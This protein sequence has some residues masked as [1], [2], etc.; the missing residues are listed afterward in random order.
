MD[1]RPEHIWQSARESGVRSK[2]ARRVDRSLPAPQAGYEVPYA[3]SIGELRNLVDDGIVRA[4]G[5]S[6]VGP[7]EVRGCRH[8]GEPPRVRSEPLLAGSQRV[9]R[10]PRALYEVGA[11]FLARS[12]LGGKES[13]EIKGN[14]AFTAMGDAHGVGPHGSASLG[15]SG[16]PRRSSR[17]RESRGAGWTSPTMRRRGF[18]Q[19]CRESRDWYGLLPHRRPSGPHRGPLAGTAVHINGRPNIDRRKLLT[20]LKGATSVLDIPNERLP[21]EAGEGRL[22]SVARRLAG[23]GSTSAIRWCL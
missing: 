10:G 11:R 19:R 7:D 22:R 20:C 21:S 17:S 18:R 13:N 2:T 1:R 6:N 12:T 3:A 15:S 5:I 16:C 9:P 4:V 8:L 14:A 23:T